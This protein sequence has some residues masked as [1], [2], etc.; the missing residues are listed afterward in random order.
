MNAP[1]STSL[2]LELWLFALFQLAWGGVCL[3]T[4]TVPHQLNPRAAGNTGLG[5][6]FG[7]V[8]ELNEVLLC[9]L[10]GAYAIGGL[11]LF[12]RH[13][14]GLLPAIG[15]QLLLSLMF[16][17]VTLILVSEETPRFFLSNNGLTMLGVLAMSSGILW[18]L[19]VFHR[20]LPGA[21]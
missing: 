7:V 11:T 13:W 2:R 1:L 20:A 3:V 8:A 16:L 10:A 15:V 4:L 14:C 9:F 21:K 17:Y 12:L 5:S 19:L 18:R 6:M